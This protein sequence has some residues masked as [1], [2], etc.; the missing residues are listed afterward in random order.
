MGGGA[1][2]VYLHLRSRWRASISASPLRCSRRS[3]A[4]I[5]S[6]S[7]PPPEQKKTVAGQDCR[8]RHPVRLRRHR[9]RSRQRPGLTEDH[10]RSRD[11]RRQDRRL[12]D[13]RQQAV[14]QQRRHRR[15]LHRSW[16]TRLPGQ[17]GSLSTKA[18]KG[19]THDKPEDKHGIRLSNTAALALNDVYVDADRL[20]GGVEGQGLIQA[21]LV[22]G[23]TRLM[24]A[25][26]GLGAGWAALD[27]AIPYSTK[28]IQARSAAL[29]K[30]GLH[31][32]ADR[33]SRGAIWKPAAPISKRPRSASMPATKAA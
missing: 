13:Q 29:G 3:W 16:P 24:V 8:R 10:R 2:D 11:G 7:A 9:T 27:R 23:Y 14:D 6:P 26:F 1:F 32:Q 31:P 30:A 20:V 25:A 18:R 21:Q 28:R 4:A 33:A 17:A 22:F 12:Q 19:F 5:P 15:L